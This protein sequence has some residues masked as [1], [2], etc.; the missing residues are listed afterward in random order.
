VK[1]PFDPSAGG[2]GSTRANAG[3]GVPGEPSRATPARVE[4]RPP[5]SKYL[6]F[7]AA[8]TGAAIMIVE[9]LGAR[10]LAPYFGTSH[11]VWTAQIAVTLVALAVGY[12][13]GGRL[14]DAS[15]KLERM[16]VGI[17]IAAAYLCFAVLLVR[18]VAYGCLRFNLAAGSLLA[19]GFLFFIP[20][21]LLAMVGPFF[22]RILTGSVASV[23]G[24]V[25]RLTAIGTLGSFLGTVLIGYWLI[26]ALPNSI[27]MYGTAIALMLVVGGY[28]L[29]WSRKR[30]APVA[31]TV[32][33]AAGLGAYAVNVDARAQFENAT[34]LARE[35]SPFGLLQVLQEKHT[36]RRYYLNDYLIQ[37]TYDAEAKQSLSMFTYMLHLLAKAYTPE[38]TNV[39]CIGLGV[40]IVPTQFAKEGLAVDVVEINPD[41]VPLAQK[42]F[43]LEPARLNITIG[44]GRY[45]VNQTKK[46]YDAIILDAFLGD[47]SP[48]HLMTR[49]AF[50]E[51]RRALKPNGTLVINSFG[52]FGPGRD[53][54]TASIYKSLASVFNSI[55]I[56]A[57]G[58]HGNT[59]FVAS[60]N[61]ELKIVR[62]PDLST[63]HRNSSNEVAAAFDNLREVT[64]TSGRILTDNYNPVEV[65]DAVNREELRRNLALG[66][67]KL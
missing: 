35:N 66:V 33:A 29:V 36:S 6:Y 17:L 16:Y 42:F 15:P 67:R 7:T 48:S 44:D 64:P 1:K 52:D 27:S 55:R 30:V 65:Y 45:F 57:V 61:P 18:P 49:E 8:V 58:L 47:S 43:D 46:K 5:N 40:G 25:G 39:L 60:A 59:L 31:V 2:R 54:L 10:M 63:V 51:M 50:G 14:V 37:N 38:L 21:V 28:F 53:F 19:S 12:Y 62:L 9:I 24:N 4:P 22:V 32:I 23:G 26:P 41:V 34:E 56:H 13:A 3:H 20:L 11:F